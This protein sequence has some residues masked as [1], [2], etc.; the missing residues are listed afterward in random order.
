MK[1]ITNFFSANYQS[2]QTAEIP[3]RI[4]EYWASALHFWGRAWW[5]EV[6]TSQPKC[7]YYF[8]PF[9]N[10]KEAERLMTGYVEDL[11]GEYAQ[12]IQAKIRRCKPDTLTIEGDD[13]SHEQKLAYV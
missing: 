8:G 5:I 12:G 11:E 3:V 6:S 10:S 9:A 13:G 1:F 4:S 2:L 7:L